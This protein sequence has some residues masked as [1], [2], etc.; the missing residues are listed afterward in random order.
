[1]P[2]PDKPTYP[3][4]PRMRRNVPRAIIDTPISR[5]IMAASLHIT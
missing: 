4:W 2:S 5:Q 3:R 1:M